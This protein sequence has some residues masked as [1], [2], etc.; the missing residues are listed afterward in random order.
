MSTDPR[1]RSWVEIQPRALRRNLH[2]IREAIGG[3]SSIIPMVKADGYGLGMEQVVR[4]VER[5]DPLGYGVATVEEGVRLRETGVEKPVIVFSPLPPNA[6]EPAV[7]HALTVT[8][9]DVDSVERLSDAATAV[10]VTARF[11]VEV[12]TGMG[13][14][15]FD[16]LRVSEWGP[17]VAG[18]A[19]ATLCW[20]GCYTHFHSADSEDDGATMAQWRRFT[21]TLGSLERET[22][23]L[24]HACNAAAA[25]RYSSLAADVVRPGIFLYGGGVGPGVPRPEEVARVRARVTFIRD[26]AE[27]ATAGYGA[28]YRA[29]GRERWAT[30]G[31][32]YGDGLPRI[33]GN[34]GSAL[35]LGRRVPI[36][37]R[38]SMDMTVVD[39]TGA[40]GV[41]VGDTAT[42]I[43]TDG[44]ESITL[45]EVAD[46]AGTISYEI[47]TGLTPRLPRVWLASEDA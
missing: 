10:G 23:G 6:Y 3:S 37:G 38:I 47:L 9:S 43:G 11:Q 32:G 44:E 16:W 5:D 42:L 14:A 34:R 20:E 7:A 4:T 31:I 19:S 24:T 21:E 36:I 27:G 18:R 30:L 22:L 33:L 26:V 41:T 1:T 25:L 40:E 39:I 29:S 2:R 13:R 46:L 28:T 17:A 45:D 8:I 15:G 35:I 12:D